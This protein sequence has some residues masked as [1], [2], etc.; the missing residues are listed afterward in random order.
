MREFRSVQAWQSSHK[1]ITL[2]WAV[3]YARLVRVLRENALGAHDITIWSQYVTIWSHCD[4]RCHMRKI[5]IMSSDW[6]AL[7]G[8]LLM[9]NIHCNLQVIHRGSVIVKWIGI[10]SNYIWIHTPSVTFW[11][12]IPQRVSVFDVEVSSGLFHL[13]LILPVWKFLWWI[14]HRGSVDY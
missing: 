1:L 8:M 5:E 7:L 12:N 10:L 2:L 13:N 11:L 6:I 14:F 4:P 3:Q 9:W